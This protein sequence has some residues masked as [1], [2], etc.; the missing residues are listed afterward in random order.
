M[1][2]VSCTLALS[3]RF[4]LLRSSI[5]DYWQCI[6]I[7]TGFLSLARVLARP[8]RVFWTALLSFEK[9]ILH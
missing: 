6:E 5:A 7:V 9:C 4:G 3:T 8:A 2:L 1:I